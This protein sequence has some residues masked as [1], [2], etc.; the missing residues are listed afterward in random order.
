MGSSEKE[1]RTE[2]KNIKQKSKKKQKKMLT[3]EIKFD[4]LETQLAKKT[5][6]EEKISEN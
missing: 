6:S 4:I 2:E 5:R 3:K 1:K